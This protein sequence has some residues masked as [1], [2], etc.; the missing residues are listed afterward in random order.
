MLVFYFDRT[1]FLSCYNPMSVIRMS[2]YDN[3]QFVCVF[4]IDY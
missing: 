4:I 1:F 3:V 2:S